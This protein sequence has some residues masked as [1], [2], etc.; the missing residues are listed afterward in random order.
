M[1]QETILALLCTYCQEQGV[2]REASV[3]YSFSGMQH[4][5]CSE[6]AWKIREKLKRKN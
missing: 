3:L 2:K 6:H 1:K 4:G 5:V